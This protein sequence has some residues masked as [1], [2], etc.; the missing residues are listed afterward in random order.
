MYIFDI[1]GTLTIVGDRIKYLQQEKKDWDSFYE[2]C[3]EDIENRPITDLCRLI[4]R[5]YKVIYI[6]GRRE[7]VRG[8]TKTWLKDNFLW[9]NRS[10][11]YM[12][13]DGDFRH[14]TIVKPELF[15]ANVLYDDVTAIFEDRDSMVKTWR[16]LG[17]KCLQVADG[18]F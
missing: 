7:S 2:A 6:T 14:D 10:E 15:Y 12:R 18:K 17:L 13:P 8:K 16:S 1:D 11:L 3:D 9:N 4:M 5:E